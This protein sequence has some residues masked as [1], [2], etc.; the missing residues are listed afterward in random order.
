MRHYR[1]FAFL[2]LS[3]QTAL[4]TI[5]WRWSEIGPIKLAPKQFEDYLRT[6]EMEIRMISRF[7]PTRFL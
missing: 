4:E 1:S 3:P 6:D 7:N 2:I 5:Y